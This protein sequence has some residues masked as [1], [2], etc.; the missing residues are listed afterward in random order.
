[1]GVGISSLQKLSATITAGLL[2]VAKVAERTKNLRAKTNEDALDNAKKGYES[3]ASIKAQNKKIEKSYADL[4]N[5]TMPGVKDS[6]TKP[7]KLLPQPKQKF[8][9][10]EE[11]TGYPTIRADASTTGIDAKDEDV[12]T[13]IKVREKNQ[14]RVM[15]G[16]HA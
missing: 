2:A 7:E 14:N 15:G 5:S 4:L 12:A 10:S 16:L 9:L 1:M 11:G 8:T 13:L 6:K 3:A